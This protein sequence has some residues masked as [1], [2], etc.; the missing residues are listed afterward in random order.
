MTKQSI[1]TYI[2]LFLFIFTTGE[3]PNQNNTEAPI[4]TTV[5]TPQPSTCPPVDCPEQKISSTPTEAPTTAY[6]SSGGAVYIRWGRTVCPDS[7]SL[8]YK[9][10]NMSLHSCQ[11][12][13]LDMMS[14]LVNCLSHAS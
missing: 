1:Y 10:L 8:V 6:G 12:L 13:G 11:T 4:P 14:L 2:C 3:I 5:D 7:A 9:G